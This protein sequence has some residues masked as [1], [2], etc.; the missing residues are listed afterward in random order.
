M[1]SNASVVKGDTGWIV[2]VHWGFTIETMGPYR[3]QWV[4][5]VVAW[6]HN[7]IH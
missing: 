5:K 7:G 3:W 1:T 2:K 4:A 6:F